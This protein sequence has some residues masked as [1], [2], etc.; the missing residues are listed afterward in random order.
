MPTLVCESQTDVS[1]A[2]R[3]S[4]SA[5]L[6]NGL[7]H[8][9]HSPISSDSNCF[10]DHMISATKRALIT[11]IDYE[12]VNNF[13][14]SVQDSLKSKYIVLKPSNSPIM[15][16]VNNTT[17]NSINNGKLNVNGSTSNDKQTNGTGKFYQRANKLKRKKFKK[18]TGY[19]VC[20][21]VIHCCIDFEAII[22]VNIRDKP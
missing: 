13:S 22:F 19:C 5:A 14:Y 6:N 20:H 18:S 1:S 8:N 21:S 16:T 10:Q 7:S 2:I 12:E 11:D 3:S 4:L 15:Q 17:I 9:G